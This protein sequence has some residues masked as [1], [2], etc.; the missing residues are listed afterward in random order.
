MTKISE[1]LKAIASFIEKKDCL[2]DV[3]C[4]HGLLSI[5]LVENN[6]AERV[7]ASDINLNAL[8]NAIDN[9]KKRNL[10]IDTI[11]SDGI[12]DVDMDG[13]NTLVISG[14]GT[15]TILHVLSDDK[16]IKDVKK[17][18][19]QSNNDYELLRRKMNIKGFYLD[20]EVYTYERKKWYITCCFVKNDKK[21][22]VKEIKYG[23]LNN[24]RYNNYLL[25]K[26]I[27]I[28]KKIPWSSF[29]VKFCK[30]FSIIKLKKTI[31]NKK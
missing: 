27:K 29:K 1:R 26:E 17:I 12:N 16:K 8:N 25:D 22:T 10:K 20:D 5:Y 15:S 9:I 18:I 31:Y 19:I 11:L 2:V 23:F 30:L 21:N 4:D 28:F 24:N 14:M 3:G 6:L 13:I 7:V